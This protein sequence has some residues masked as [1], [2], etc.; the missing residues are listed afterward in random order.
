MWE[1]LAGRAPPFTQ[2]RPIQF[3]TR[4]R[5]G[6]CLIPKWAVHYEVRSGSR[7]SEATWTRAPLALQVHRPLY[8]SVHAAPTVVQN[9]HPGNELR[10]SPPSGASL[11]RS[12]AK[13]NYPNGQVLDREGRL[14][15]C[16]QGSLCTPSR[17]SR[18]DLA[19]PEAVETLVDKYL[20]HVSHCLTP[21][22][23]AGLPQ[24]A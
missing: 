19:R 23:R 9:S 13:A 5:G 21:P 24:D 15:T 14:L 22:T 18:T 4:H 1:L 10:P 7:K 20:T 6:G 8:D 2:R 3:L 11:P 17:I 16:E 12:S